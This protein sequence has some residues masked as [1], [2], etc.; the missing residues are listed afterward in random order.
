V[1]LV[2][3]DHPQVEL[4]HGVRVRALQEVEPLGLER[5]EVVELVEAPLVQLEVGLEERQLL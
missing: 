1:R 2:Q 4:V 3:V 5:V